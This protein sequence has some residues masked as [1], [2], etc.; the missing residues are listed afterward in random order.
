MAQ[1]MPG[2][3]VRHLREGF[4]PDDS[5]FTDTAR[6]LSGPAALAHQRAAEEMILRLA[7]RLR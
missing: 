7:K 3:A 1:V 4:V 6:E 2:A 5:R